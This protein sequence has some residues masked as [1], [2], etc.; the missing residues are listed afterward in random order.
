MRVNSELFL[1]RKDFWKEFFVS[2]LFKL[3]IKGVR[4]RTPFCFGGLNLY[5]RRLPLPGVVTAMR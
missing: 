3:I 5:A 2:E 1:S 4:I